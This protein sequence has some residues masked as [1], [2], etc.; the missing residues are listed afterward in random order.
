MCDGSD[1]GPLLISNF[2]L[3]GFSDVIVKGEVRPNRN[4]VPR[5]EPEAGEI[6]RH[7]VVVEAAL[8]PGGIVRR[9]LNHAAASGDGHGVGED[10]WWAVDGLQDVLFRQMPQRLGPFDGGKL[11]REI[12]GF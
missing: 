1:D 12:E 7:I 3:G 9:A 6:E 10:S 5:H 4:V 11:L 8:V 2:G